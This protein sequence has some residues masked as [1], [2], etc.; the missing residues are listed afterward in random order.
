[1][2]I[3]GYIFLQD[4]ENLR[5]LPTTTGIYIFK[6]AQEILYIGKSVNIK[7]RVLSHIEN[8]KLIAKEDSIVQTSDRIEWIITDSEFKALLLESSLIQ[9][10]KPKYNSRW[11]DDKSYLY[12][13]ITIKDEFPKVLTTRKENDGLSLYFGP[14][15]YLKEVEEI[16]KEMRKVFPFCTQKNISKRPCFYSKIK[17]CDPCPNT[18]SLLLDREERK[19]MK[20]IYRKNIRH[21]ITILN[22]NTDKVLKTLYRNLK[23]LS[24]KQEYEKALTLRNRVHRFERLVN[25]RSFGLNYDDRFNT[26]AESVESL[27]KLLIHFFPNLTSL[28]RIECYD[29]SNLSQMDATASMVVLHDGLIQKSEY[30]KFKIKNLKLQSDFEMLE[31][32]MKRRWNNDWEKPNLIVIDGGK[33]QV[34]IIDTTLGKLQIAIPFIGIAKHPDRLVIGQ[35]HFPMVR[36]SYNNPGFNLLRLLRDESHRF[37]KKYHVFLRDKKM[38]P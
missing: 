25:Q 35:D 28:H 32:V 1:M 4:K 10:Y 17:L 20:A 29:I 31:E 7:A 11:K 34:R 21:V 38:V 5:D 30:R 19:R 6:R 12:I 33:P 26:S 16:V 18:I 13:K 15:S 23:E 22:G 27:K 9:K 2:K 14:F 37:A 3:D 24:Q 36:P 8:S